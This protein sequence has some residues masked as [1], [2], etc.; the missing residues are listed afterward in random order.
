M[1]RAKA[2]ERENLPEVLSGRI[3]I[4]L[5]TSSKLFG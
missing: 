5:K 2:F 1:S 4:L 3:W